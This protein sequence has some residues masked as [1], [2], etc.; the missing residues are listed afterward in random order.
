MRSRDKLVSQLRT[1]LRSSQTRPYLP[2]TTNARNMIPQPRR[3]PLQPVLLEPGPTR[4]ARDDEGEDEDDEEHDDEDEH[5]DEVDGQEALLLPVGAHESCGGDD[6]E[7]EAEEDERPTEPEE[8]L[9]VRARRQPDARG[10][11]GE[12]AHHR[13][14]VQ[15]CRDAIANSHDCVW[16]CFG[17]GKWKWKQKQRYPLSDNRIFAVTLISSTT[18]TTFITRKQGT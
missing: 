9:V 12:G 14:E 8:A 16:I 17:K 11:D 15:D 10:D 2:P 4:R 5:G 18:T 7:G 6:K 13:H 1:N 3:E